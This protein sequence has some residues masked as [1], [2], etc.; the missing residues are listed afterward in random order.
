MKTSDVTN[1]STV[2]ETKKAVKVEYRGL[3]S[4][5]KNAK[6]CVFPRSIERPIMHCDEFD[7]FEGPKTLV[8]P[9]LKP[10]AKPEETQFKGLCR[11]CEN[12]HHCVFPKPASGVWHCD[13]YH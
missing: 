4:T 5:C 13:E 8:I 2:Q 1:T 12:R 9:R 7:G 10:E 11:N 6:H 3:C